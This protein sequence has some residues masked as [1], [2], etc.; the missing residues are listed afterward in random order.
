MAKKRQSQ[1]NIE[2]IIAELLVTLLVRKGVLSWL[3]AFL[4]KKTF[5][6][7]FSRRQS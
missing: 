6:Q 4:K 5:L 2:P 7:P 3:G 1:K